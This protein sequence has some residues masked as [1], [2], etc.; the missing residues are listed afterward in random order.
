MGC[1]WPCSSEPEPQ[2]PVKQKD[3]SAVSDAQKYR[4]SA[5][6]ASASKNQSSSSSAAQPVKLTKRQPPPPPPGPALGAAP[7][8][9]QNMVP[10]QAYQG[11]PY[12][13]GPPAPGFHPGY[14]GQQGKFE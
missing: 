3:S 1:C 11:N 12:Q 5:P 7:P 10:Q 6:P 14:Q 4:P 2:E 9:Q 13:Q 8:Y